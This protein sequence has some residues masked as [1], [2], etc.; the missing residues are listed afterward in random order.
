MKPDLL[1]D[2]RNVGSHPHGIAR[3]TIACLRALAVSPP[4][5]TTTVLISVP[6]HPDFPTQTPWMDYRLSMTPCYSPGEQLRLPTVILKTG[7]GAYF[8]PTFTGPVAATVPMAITI[9]DLIHLRF[10]AEYGARQRIFYKTVVSALV[11]RSR[12]VATDSKSSAAEV[13]GRWPAASGKIAVLG[14]PVESP[15]VPAADRAAVTARLRQIG[16]EGPFLLFVGNPKGHKNFATA[17]RAFRRIASDIPGLSLVALGITPEGA[18]RA[19]W[20]DPRLRLLVPQ[21]VDSLADLYR[22]ASAFV[23]P[24]FWEG[25]GLPVLEAMACGTPVV[26]SDIPVY[27]ENLGEAALFADPKEPEAFASALRRVLSSDRLRARL[28]EAGFRAAA[29][30]QDA[31]AFRG[32]LLGALGTLMTKK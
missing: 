12:V 9:H 26:A 28:I 6:Y 17:Y 19:G 1:F 11:R 2:A 30:H 22:G 20:T 14:A 32:R 25:F 3:F 8:S 18:K 5:F 29:P 15:F 23:A 31:S 21:A 16:I 13:A 10:P 27:R 4:G 24:S 7:A